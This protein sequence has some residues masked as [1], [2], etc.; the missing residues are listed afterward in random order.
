MERLVRKHI[1]ETDRENFFFH[2]TNIWSGTKYY[3]D[4]DAWPLDRRLKI[5]RDLVEIPEKFSLPIVFGYCPRN[6][7]LTDSSGVTLDASRRDVVVHSVAFLECICLVEKIMRK[8]WPAEVA[9]LIAEDRPIVRK[10]LREVQSWAQ[11]KTVP[12]EGE[13]LEYLP[14][15]HIRDTVYWAGKREARLLQLA[16]ICAFVIRRHLDN[17]RHNQPLYS[18][19]HPMMVAH[20]KTDH[21]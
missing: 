5:L 10:N 3:K 6:K 15:R 9:I 20:P 21:A 18:K 11:N 8:C 12:H 17:R 7:R 4:R 14:F 16:D 19:L 2:A 13:E 1:P